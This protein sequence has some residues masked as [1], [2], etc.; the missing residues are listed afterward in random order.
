MAN[1]K[2]TP[3]VVSTVRT[4]TPEQERHRNAALSKAIEFAKVP[5]LTNL[6]YFAWRWIA[7]LKCIGSASGIELTAYIG[8][9]LVEWTFQGINKM[10]CKQIGN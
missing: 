1:L 4:R 6:I 3:A 10:H 9:L 7:V 5:L 2:P 8:F